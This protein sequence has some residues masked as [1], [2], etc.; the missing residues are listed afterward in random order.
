MKGKI[1]AGLF[2]AGLLLMIG[3]AGASDLGAPLAET[4]PGALLGLAMMA[5]GAYGLRAEDRRRERKKAVSRTE[6]PPVPRMGCLYPLGVWAEMDDRD[7]GIKKDPAAGR[8]QS[9]ARENN[10]MGQVYPIFSEKSRGGK[11][12]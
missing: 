10:S 9:H 2:I 11:K 12:A 3:K 6:D 4:V 8:P 1:C 7:A 5:A